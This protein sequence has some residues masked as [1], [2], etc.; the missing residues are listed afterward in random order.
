ML[1]FKR[2]YLKTIVMRVAPLLRTK[3]HI[4]KRGRERE[5]RGRERKEGEREKNSHYTSLPLREQPPGG[6][7]VT[8][9]KERERKRKRREREREREKRKKRKKEREKRRERRCQ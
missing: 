8:Y 9:R 4:G 7:I 3:P 6:K 5:K 1:N 2:N